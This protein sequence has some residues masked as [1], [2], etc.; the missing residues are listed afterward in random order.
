[1]RLLWESSAVPQEV[2]LITMQSNNSTSGYGPR[3][4]DSRDSNRYLHTRVHSIVIHNSQEVEAT[5]GS[6]NR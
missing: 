5:Q 3:R 2:K 6:V 1:M 4:T